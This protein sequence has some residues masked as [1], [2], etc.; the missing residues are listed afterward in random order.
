MK[1]KANAEIDRHPRKIEQCRRAAAREEASHLVQV[2]RLA[3]W[4][5]GQSGGRMVHLA[6]GLA[7][8]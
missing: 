2:A 7:K 5:V 4:V 8:Q 1:E 3:S 6:K